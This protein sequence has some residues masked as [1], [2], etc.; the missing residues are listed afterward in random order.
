VR[1]FSSHGPEAETCNLA[2]FYARSA[3]K[4]A[5]NV[6]LD[7]A[8]RNLPLRRMPHGPQ[9]GKRP[10]NSNNS[11]NSTAAT[12]TAAA[13]N[14][15]KKTITAG[16]GKIHCILPLF[17]GTRMLPLDGPIMLLLLLLLLSM[18][19]LVDCC[20]CCCSPIIKCVFHTVD[21]GFT[22]FFVR[23]LPLR[24][25]IYEPANEFAKGE[26]RTRMYIK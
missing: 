25:L 6:S 26:R 22:S 2:L 4:N 24:F 15:I 5:V 3:L 14:G 16:R 12:S 19:L 7:G 23:E 8:D 21:L 10:D 13:T 11:S 18:L 17:A 1:K 9:K 20:C